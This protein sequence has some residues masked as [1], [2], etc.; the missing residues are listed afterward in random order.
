MGIFIYAEV[1][2]SVT[3]AEW[4]KVYGETLT[5]AESFHLAERGTIT[6]AGRNV[7]CAVPSKERT[8]SGYGY[9]RTGWF[10]DMDYDTLKGAE[11]YFLPKDLVQEETLDGQ[12][13]DAMMGILPLYLDVDEKDERFCH[14]YSLWGGKTQGE[15]YHMYLL[16]IACL[17]EERLGEKAFVY[18]DITLG[19]CR[20]SVEMAN[21]YLK[22]PI[23]VPARCEMGRLYGRIQ[24]LPLDDIKKVAVFEHFYLGAKDK[25]YY[26]FVR[27]NF[28]KDVIQERWKEIFAESRVGT[29]G[30]VK[31]L[32]NYLS[33]GGDLE[34]LCDYVRLEEEGKAKYETFIK[35]VMDTKL[36]WKE[37]NTED[38][39][40]ISPESEQPYSIWTLFANVV[41]GSAHNPKVDRYVPMEEIRA[42]LKKG[43]GSKCNVDQCI[44]QYLKEEA[45]APEINVGKENL[46]QEELSKMAM[47][48]ASEVLNQVMDQKMD[49]LQELER[50]YD[51]VD[52]EDL[53]GYEKGDTVR[54]SLMEVMKKSFKFYSGLLEEQQFKDLMKEDYEK[55]SV[56]LIEQNRYLMLRDK[57]WFH[58][59]SEIKNYP[60]TYR[61]YYPM[62]RVK[63]DSMGLMQMIRAFVLNDEL[64]EYLREQ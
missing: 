50:K 57:D 4:R 55:K 30:F 16:A 7:I 41:L 27:E 39:L 40:E 12:A 61:R 63:C 11:E 59:F 45:D 32:K 9:T 31:N 49:E 6:Y 21:K 53:I 19:Q 5:L 42:A 2:K 36:H 15:P 62:V 8:I 17:I 26:D 10:A 64:Y 60:D 3:K 43:I 28:R 35:E 58:I 24:K 38:C 47:A 34:N 25:S 48:D 23:R 52:Y 14:T 37:K 54:P 29:R 18:G 56:F 22:K 46:S 1:S 33:S 51:I 13:G 20:K 44:E